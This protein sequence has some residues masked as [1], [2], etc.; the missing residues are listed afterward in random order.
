MLRNYVEFELDLADEWK[1]EGLRLLEPGGL[2]HLRIIAARLAE[3]VDSVGEPWNEEDNGWAF[4]CKV[5]RTS[6]SV[7]IASTEGKGRFLVIVSPVVLF[8][9]L[10]RKRAAEAVQNV[11]GEIDGLLKS[12]RRIRNVRWCTAKEYEAFSGKKA[13]AD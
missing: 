12:D 6:V 7:L 13:K 4:L 5:G 8:R 10:C 9:F 11:C 3:N 2:A 1:W